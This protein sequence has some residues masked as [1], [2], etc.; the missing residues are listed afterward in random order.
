MKKP[1]SLLLLISCAVFSQE[2]DAPR[3]H[4]IG[5]NL[6]PLVIPLYSNEFKLDR[7]ELTYVY[8][9][10]KSLS[11]RARLSAQRTEDGGE[12]APFGPGH[13]ARSRTD[14]LSTNS[15]TTE[16]QMF[17][18]KEVS[19]IRAYLSAE[20][21]KPFGFAQFYVGAGVVPGLVK[22]HSY[23]Y[24]A[25]YTTDTFL[26][27]SAYDGGQ[28]FRTF[29]LGFTPYVG[30]NVPI[31]KRLFLNFQTGIEFDYHFRNL[32]PIDG[33]PRLE[34]QKAEWLIWPVMNE[35]GIYFKF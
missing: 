6:A 22:N 9:K 20:Y 4:A 32:R 28:Y 35:L 19:S 26:G 21:V 27:Y 16:L 24:R 31:T 10:S 2:T 15:N 30:L 14:T 8:Q 3:K 33:G 23:A 12:T 7:A 5:L 18:Q 34:T 11:F 29:M 25:E 1:L 13:Y 17:Y